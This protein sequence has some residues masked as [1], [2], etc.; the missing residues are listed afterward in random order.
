M[1][2]YMAGPLFTQGERDFN[3][4]V[5]AKLRAKGYEVYLPQEQTYA[6]GPDRTGRI[7]RNDLDHVSHCDA[8]V[9]MCEYQQVDDGTAWELGYA[10]ALGKKIFALRTDQRVV[11]P[12]EQINLMILMSLAAKPF[13]DVDS[14]VDALSRAIPPR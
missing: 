9:A 5:A 14:L 7:Y 6:E 4:V 2:I 13:S 1:K 11:K 10:T 3:A 8:V 12:D